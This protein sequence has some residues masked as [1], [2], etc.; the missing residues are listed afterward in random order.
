MSTNI[1]FRKYATTKH[2]TSV[3][4]L[5]RRP[6]SIEILHFQSFWMF[7][8][9]FTQP[10]CHKFIN[11][12]RHMGHMHVYLPLMLKRCWA[13]ENF[14]VNYI[15]GWKRFKAKYSSF[16]FT[17]LIAI[18]IHVKIIVFPHFSWPYLSCLPCRD[19]NSLGPTLFIVYD[20]TL[21][22][23]LCKTCNFYAHLVRNAGNLRLK[24]INFTSLQ[25]LLIVPVIF[26]DNR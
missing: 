16:T 17:L 26:Y 12:E 13:V 25:I 6:Y 14:T 4:S 3:L 19:N 23:N 8:F 18:K 20:Q 7:F 24:L 10:F 1:F 15:W 9:L 11:F 5:L 21:T 2:V 22:F